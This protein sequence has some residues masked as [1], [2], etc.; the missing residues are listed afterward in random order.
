MDYGRGGASTGVESPRGRGF[1][2]FDSFFEQQGFALLGDRLFDR[3]ELAENLARR[4][5]FGELEGLTN[6]FS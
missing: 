5:T 2:T 6:G 4:R 1:N 3:E